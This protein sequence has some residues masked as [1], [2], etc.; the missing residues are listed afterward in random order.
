MSGKLRS[1]TGSSV[2]KAAEIKGK[3][4]F[5]LPLGT[6][7][8]LMGCRPSMTNLSMDMLPVAPLWSLPL[9]RRLSAHS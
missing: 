9:S 6:T 3:A 1:V 8:P 4:A 5:L 2:S 7:V